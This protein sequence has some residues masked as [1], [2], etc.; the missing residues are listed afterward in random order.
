MANHNCTWHI[1]VQDG[2]LVTLKFS[3]LDIEESIGCKH[4][5]ITVRD[6]LL[7]TSPV[8]HRL[9]GKGLPKTILSS[10]NGISVQ[11]ITNNRLEAAGFIIDYAKSAPGTTTHVYFKHD[12]CSF[13]RLSQS[14]YE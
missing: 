2:F 12:F 10:S 3:M 13:C 11:F 9:C 8:L 7:Q 14:G 5:Y 4:D 1:T 6:G